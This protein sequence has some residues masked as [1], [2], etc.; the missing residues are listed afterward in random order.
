MKNIEKKYQCSF[1]GFIEKLSRKNNLRLAL[2]LLAFGMAACTPRLASPVIPIVIDTPAHSPSMNPTNI[3]T[4]TIS[5]TQPLNPALLTPSAESARL[6]DI[7]LKISDDLPCQEYG[8]SSIV[9]VNATEAQFECSYTDRENKNTIY[10]SF[11]LSEDRLGFEC[12][13]GYI[14][15]SSESSYPVHEGGENGKT[16]N[17]YTHNERFFTW[18]AQGVNFTIIEFIDGN[19]IPVLA[20]PDLR[21]NI[22]ERVTQL[23]LINGDGD[24]CAQ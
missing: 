14:A 1:H 8:W 6:G 11:R 18:T 15:S 4:L 12:F 23:G 16:S 24:D 20:S 3:D 10:I 19:Q 17:S 13:H 2:L 5:P 9:M 21:E 22:Y 7:L